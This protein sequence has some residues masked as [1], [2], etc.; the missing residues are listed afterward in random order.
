MMKKTQTAPQYRKRPFLLI[1]L[2]LALSLGCRFGQVLP[3]AETGEN[4]TE[5]ASFFAKSAEPE[6]VE[7]ISAGTSQGNPFSPGTIVNLNDWEI[8]LLESLRDDAAWQ[9]I[10]LANSNNQ[11]APDGWEYLLVKMRIKNNSSSAEKKYISVH[12]TGNGRLLHYELQQQRHPARSLAGNGPA[13]R[14]RKHRLGDIS[15]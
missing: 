6:E 13:R 10:H 14:R 4:D 7:V 1:F 11:Q 12:V 9:E 2:W 15:R 3:V 8:E 5:V